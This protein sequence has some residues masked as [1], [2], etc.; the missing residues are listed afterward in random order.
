[1]LLGLVALR[2][3]L[4][5]F[6]DAFSRRSLFDWNSSQAPMLNY[7]TF[8]F[9]DIWAFVTFGDVSVFRRRRIATWKGTTIGIHW[10]DSFHPDCRPHTRSPILSRQE[11]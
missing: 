6:K 5:L 3:R 7:Q 10:L 9:A 11:I 1:M 8:F 2:H 4:L